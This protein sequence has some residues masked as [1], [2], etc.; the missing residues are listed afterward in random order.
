M[1]RS[2]NNLRRLRQSAREHFH[3]SSARRGLLVAFE[4]PDGSGKTTQRKLFKTWLRSEGYE[5]T[6]TK[7]NS[8][9]LIK[10]IIKSRKAVHAL[11]PEEFSLLHSAD[12]R[13]RVEQIILPALWQRH[14]VIADRFLFTG[15]ARDVARGLDLDWVLKLYEPL[16]WPDLVFYF[17]VSPAT[18]GRRITATRAPQFY[19]AGQDVT[20]VDDP[21]ESYQR[22]ITRVIREYESL[23][24][25]FNFITVDAER[26]IGEQ[27]H[28]I[29]GLFR[30]GERRP[31]SEWN[32]DAVAEWLSQAE[33]AA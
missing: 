27:H 1:Q 9:D 15:L 4:G 6:T 30:E 7:W 2:K 14:V 23:A 31:W 3:D 28:H 19:E 13:H 20:D 5:V 26:S 33:V 11:S 8:S 12:F 18:S 32:V 24:L 16:V 22:F 17:S 29:R 21:V 25:I 10:P